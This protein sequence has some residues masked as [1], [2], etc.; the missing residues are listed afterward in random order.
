MISGV[1][2]TV[3]VSTGVWVR[4][5]RW[6]QIIVVRFCF[7]HAAVT[8]HKGSGGFLSQQ[9]KQGDVLGGSC[10]LVVPAGSDHRLL[11]EEEVCFLGESC[12]RTFPFLC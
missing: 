1:W 11:A 9:V 4:K 10:S 8:A 3:W 5:K 12:A 2:V 7:S 6:L